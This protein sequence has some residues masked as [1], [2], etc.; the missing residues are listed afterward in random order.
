M[1]FLTAPKYWRETH[2]FHHAHVSNMRYSSTGSYPVMTKQM[3]QEASRLERLHY[4]ISRHPLTYAFAYLTVFLISNTIEPFLRSP[5][6]NW[7]SGAALLVHAGLIAGLWLAGGFWTAFFGF[8]LPYTIAGAFGAY[9]FY[10]QHNFAGMKILREDEWNMYDASMV[11]TSYLK[12]DP[13]LE[14]CTGS[15]GYHHVHHLNAA[16]PFYRLKEAHK[17]IPELQKVPTVRLTPRDI[18]QGLRQKVWDPDQG[19]MLTFKEARL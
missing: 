3:W 16:I 15:I 5:R 18:W 17:A 9:L 11:S 2:N 12:L 1:L 4:R 8:I 13:I 7:S 14:W 6:K 19:R 10:V